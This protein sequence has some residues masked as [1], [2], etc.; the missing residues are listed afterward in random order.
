MQ[1][2]IILTGCGLQRE[3]SSI[4]PKFDKINCHSLSFGLS[5]REQSEKMHLTSV[6][7]LFF[8]DEVVKRLT[9]VLNVNSIPQFG[10]PSSVLVI[11][12]CTHILV[13][14]H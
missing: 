7:T 14:P 8:L 2:K 6:T 5:D 12:S 1:D 13:I 10:C 9:R 4:R 11:L 3:Y